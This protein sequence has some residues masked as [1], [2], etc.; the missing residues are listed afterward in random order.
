MINCV[1]SGSEELD[2]SSTLFKHLTC[3]YSLYS[4]GPVHLFFTI[5]TTSCSSDLLFD[6]SP[7]TL[8]TGP[9]RPQVTDPP[10]IHN[11]LTWCKFQIFLLGKDQSSILLWHN[12]RSLFLMCLKWNNIWNACRGKKPQTPFLEVWLYLFS[13]VLMGRLLKRVLWVAVIIKC[14]VR[15]DGYGL[16]RTSRLLHQV[17]FAP[18][19]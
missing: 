14:P 1:R 15:S 7:L 4:S 12:K 16:S 13:C 9:L 19:L 8:P 5:N 6:L 2:A 18:P 11:L 3:F 10:P 17:S